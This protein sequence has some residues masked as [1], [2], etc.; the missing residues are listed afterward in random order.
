MTPLTVRVDMCDQND[1]A[2]T[3]IVRWTPGTPDRGPD[4]N[5]AGGYPGDPPDCELLRIVDVEPGCDTAWILANR[6]EWICEAAA[7]EA[8]EQ[9]RDAEE[10]WAE[11]AREAREIAGVGR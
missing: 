10:R 9:A 11:Y 7:E 4:M 5:C 3:F 1:R 8:A 6:W 2:A